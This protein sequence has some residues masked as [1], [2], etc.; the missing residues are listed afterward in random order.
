MAEGKT[1]ITRQKRKKNLTHKN[2]MHAAKKLY[3]KK[4]IGNISIEE[5]TEYAD[6]SR[7]T[8][9]SHFASLEILSTEI[10]CKA[11]DEILEFYRQSGKN[12]IA[13]IKVLLEKLVDDT[14]PYPYFSTEIFM[15]G[16]LKTRGKTAFYE[17]EHV[18]YEELK[19]ANTSKNSF[20]IEEQLPLILGSYF[21]NIYQKLI[22]GEETYNPEEIK[23]TINKFIDNLIGDN[24]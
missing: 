13:G 10:A 4:G 12:G 8:F 7:S 11:I 21:R 6:V 18:L 16:I 3:E 24:E 2:I 19:S 23:T 22:R 17:F 5:I 14:C 20:S 15:N 9:F 1:T